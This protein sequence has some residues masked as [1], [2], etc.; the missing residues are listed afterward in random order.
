MSATL[1]E[2]TE[3]M[4][5]LFTADLHGLNAAYQRFAELLLSGGF[6]VGVLAGD[7]MGFPSDAE[8]EVSRNK[9]NQDP[10]ESAAGRGDEEADRIAE[11]ALKNKERYYKSL[12]KKARKPI[13]F[14]MGNDD[15]ILGQ[16]IAWTNE[17]M[18]VDISQRRA[19]HG[20]YNFVGYHYTSPFVGGSFEK[21]LPDQRQDFAMLRHLI[22]QNTIL[23][24]HGPPFGILDTGGD[25]EHYGSKALRDL[26]DSTSPR[27][28][29]FGH[30]HHSHGRSD[31]SINGA[32]PHVRR[33]V[34]VD[35][36]TLQVEF[37]A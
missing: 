5:L 11:H 7:L 33:F 36:D 9:L 17:G 8:I 3:Y 16:G 21:T 18:F 15:G 14:V 31:N 6:D 37:I 35:V 4:R 29:L 20:K 26:V 10:D 22:D 23:V 1:R 19:K 13:V 25:G 34:A 32:Y 2:N 28:H 30:I 27:L 24:T 12:I